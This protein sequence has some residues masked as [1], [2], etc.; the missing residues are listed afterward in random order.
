MEENNNS[1][2][3]FMKNNSS[4]G[5]KDK[6][7]T[8]NKPEKEKTALEIKEEEDKKELDEAKKESKHNASKYAVAQANMVAA[9]GRRF[10]MILPFLICGIL[11][12]IVV[13]TRGGDWIQKLTQYGVSKLRGE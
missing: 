12:F 2:A 13:I 7:G 9:Q 3:L 4:N 5:D 8:N 1:L 6:G 10:I 11:L